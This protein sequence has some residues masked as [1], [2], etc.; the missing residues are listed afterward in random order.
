MPGIPS[1]VRPASGGQA[2]QK[3]GADFRTPWFRLPGNPAMQHACNTPQI[4]IP[5]QPLTERQRMPYPLA[6][7]DACIIY[8]FHGAASNKKSM[9]GHECCPRCPG[10]EVREGREKPSAYFSEAIS[11][12]T[13]SLTLMSKADHARA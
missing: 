4:L 6:S 11:P 7:V 2:Q 9:V 5:H 3:I 10:R 12:L 8:A 13:L 1:N